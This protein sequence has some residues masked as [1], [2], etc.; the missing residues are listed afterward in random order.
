MNPKYPE[1]CMLAATFICISS[2]A[3]G[4]DLVNSNTQVRDELVPFAY[5]PFKGYSALS[6]PCLA[7]IGKDNMKF[8]FT[9][10]PL[11]FKEIPR[12]TNT[13]ITMLEENSYCYVDKQSDAMAIIGPTCPCILIAATAKNHPSIVV[14]HDHYTSQPECFAEI[15]T[16]T[17]GTA[18]QH[19]RILLYS[20]DLPWKQFHAQGPNQTRSWFQKHGCRTQ[21]ED[22]ESLARTL[23]KKT[24]VPQQNFTLALIKQKNERR[25]KRELCS[26]LIDPSACEKTNAWG[27][28]NTFIDNDIFFNLKTEKTFFTKDYQLKSVG[29]SADHS[30]TIMR[31]A[32]LYV[33]EIRDGLYNRLPAI[34][35]RVDNCQ[36]CICCLNQSYQK[37]H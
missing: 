1:L 17:F 8:A 3:R 7:A 27:A 4:A 12:A 37:N 22:M 13:H 16:Q 30:A 9:A 15:I 33:P 26:I 23:G 20:F 21:A 10:T 34:Y 35:C 36:L 31:L 18:L 19:V 32:R 25:Q 24:G 29:L 11:P 2:F 14:A 28:Y 5:I 6:E